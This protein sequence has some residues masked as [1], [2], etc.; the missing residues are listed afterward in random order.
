MKSNEA[1]GILPALAIA[2]L[3]WLYSIFILNRFRGI[4]K[5]NR[6][7]LCALPL[8]LLGGI[9]AWISELCILNDDLAAL[10]VCASLYRGFTNWF[11]FL[12]IVN[13]RLSVSRQQI[14]SLCFVL[15]ITTLWEVQHRI[16]L[17]DDPQNCVNTTNP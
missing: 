6:I 14:G 1:L 9:A 3:G 11:G 16:V 5:F 15:I 17:V 13:E 7:E 10:Q 4:L 8:F 2:F 12:F